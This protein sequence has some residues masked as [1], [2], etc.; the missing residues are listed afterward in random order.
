MP[1]CHSLRCD[2]VLLFLLPRCECLAI[3]AVRSRT[4]GASTVSSARLA[5]LSSRCR[6]TSTTAQSHYTGEE[7]FSTSVRQRAMHLRTA[8]QSLTVAASGAGARPMVADV[9]QHISVWCVLWCVCAKATSPTHEATLLRGNSSS[10]PFRTSPRRHHGWQLMETSQI[11]AETVT[12]TAV[13]VL[14]TKWSRC[15]A[16]RAAAD[17]FLLSLC[18]GWPHFLPLRFVK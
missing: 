2:C 1:R 4:T 14:G 10:A 12:A 3:W 9:R 6:R 8:L 16:D 5:T 15:D 7:R 13:E 11:S 17:S 18:I